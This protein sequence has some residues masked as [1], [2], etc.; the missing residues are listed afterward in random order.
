MSQKIDVPYSVARWYPA[1]SPTP[2]PNRECKGSTEN[3]NASLHELASIVYAW[4]L[5]RSGKRATFFVFSIDNKVE[6]NPR[7]LKHQLR[8][9]K[10]GTEKCT[11]HIMYKY[12]VTFRAYTGL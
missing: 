6:S 9:Q 5:A 2:T 8:L 10:N 4:G 12:R 3:A 11:L 1:R 7:C